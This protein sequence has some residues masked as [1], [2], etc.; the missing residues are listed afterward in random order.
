VSRADAVW[1]VR[2]VASVLFG[3]VMCITVPS[4]LESIVFGLGIYLVVDGLCLFWLSVSGSSV[5][6]P[7]VA[8][9][10]LAWLVAL[11]ALVAPGP[12]ALA[13]LWP[14]PAV[15]W[16]LPTGVLMV[17]AARHPTS[18]SEPRLRLRA[19]GVL[20]IA[21]GL[22]LAFFPVPGVEPIAWTLG[23]FAIVSGAI[24]GAPTV[25][26]AR[27]RTLGSDS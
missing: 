10:V 14:A 22:L 12:T 6:W 19:L 4:T 2:A 11:A 9:G 7:F 18:A 1:L 16:A 13:L 24:M 8:S 23:L 26:R 21:A 3:A 27:A 17:V 20:G 15:V 25:A 5:A